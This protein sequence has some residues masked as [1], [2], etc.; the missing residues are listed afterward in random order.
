M[1]RQARQSC[2]QLICILADN[3]DS[4]A[5][6]KAEL[7]TDAIR[8]LILRFQCTGPRGRDRSYYRLV[9]ITWAAEPEI[10]PECNM[11]PI[12]QLNA[13]DV[14]L[15]GGGGP[16]DMAKALEFA[17][18]GLSRYVSEVLEPHPER[19][20]HP[21]PAVILYSDGLNET[22]DPVS[23][24]KQIRELGVDGDTVSLVAVGVS[25]KDSEPVNDDLLRSLVC[26]E[27]FF[28]ISKLRCLFDLDNGPL[29]TQRQTEK[30]STGAQSY[31]STR[32][33]NHERI[34]QVMRRGQHTN[35][36]SAQGSS[37]N[38]IG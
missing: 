3:S 12:R 34:R 4:M 26:P 27:N 35:N 14:V 13:D 29:A 5:G 30:E 23:V 21:L 7:A 28:P 24:A 15:R 9:L 36:E 1:S 22:S 10:Y 17:Y 16:S 33:R 18:A 38:S 20:S 6:A 31:A 11:I 32:E 37:E 8:E 19:S 25:A 2:P